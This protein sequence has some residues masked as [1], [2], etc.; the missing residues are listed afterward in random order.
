MIQLILV[1]FNAHEGPKVVYSLPND[2]D[3]ELKSVTEHLMDIEFN[4]D[5]FEVI[6]GDYALANCSFEIESPNARGGIDRLMLSVA[7]KHR[8]KSFNIRK[9]LDAFK[10]LIHSKKGFYINFY[11][12]HGDQ[13]KFQE[14][15]GF[16]VD[17]FASLYNE[18]ADFDQKGDYGA[19]LL[20]GLETVGKTTIIKRIMSGDFI[21]GTRPTLGTQILR[22]A[23]ENTLFTVYDVGGQKSLRSSWY[24][25]CKAPDAILFVVDATNYEPRKAE[26]TNEFN[27]IIENFE[28]LDKRL[29][30][31]A[32][33]NKIDLIP[34]I[35]RE[36]TRKQLKESIESILDLKKVGSSQNLFLISAKTN[37]GLHESMKWLV[38][39]YLL[40][41]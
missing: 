3:P 11:S 31:V 37:E 1:F 12:K 6:Q 14:N 15:H 22:T 23:I 18:L 38:S 40:R 36:E 13:A 24:N 4:D 30:I 34:D 33:V 39:E 26:Y 32:L 25:A 20:L 5:Y 35:E 2:I 28:C 41:G 29:P 19:I 9:P 21:Q 7:E 8:Q 27:R 16:L 10:K 17:S